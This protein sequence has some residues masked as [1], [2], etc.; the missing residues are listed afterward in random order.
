MPF[1]NAFTNFQRVSAG[2]VLRSLF[3]SSSVATATLPLLGIESENFVLM[4]TVRS[5]PSPLGR[6]VKASLPTVAF[7]TPN[8]SL[9]NEADWCSSLSLIAALEASLFLLS[10]S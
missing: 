1:A 9:T 4:R 3:E 7:I 6:S 2:L 5:V 8:I 10:S